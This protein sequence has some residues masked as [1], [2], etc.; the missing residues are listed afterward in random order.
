MLPS[1]LRPDGINPLSVLYEVMSVGLHELSD[2]TCLEMAV[3]LRESLTYLVD[4]VSAQRRR[5]VEYSQHI[6]GLLEKVSKLGKS[7]IDV[8]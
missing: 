3:A 1:S 5:A 4:A 7:K 6:S 8:G 2:E